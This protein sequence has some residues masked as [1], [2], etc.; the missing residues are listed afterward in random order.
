MISFN[1]I[2]LILLVHWFADFHFQSDRLARS[3]ATSISAL[4]EH[5]VIYT[6]TWIIW[7]FALF[8][9][10]SNSLGEMWIKCGIFG[11]I[12][13]VCHWITDYFTSKK[14]KKLFDMQD[15]HNG[16]VV[17]GFDQILHYVQLF[18]TYIWL[19]DLTV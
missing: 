10:C 18:A 5:I 6:F 3:K 15:F 12:T 4:T 9:A 2:I 17:I 19:R 13:F 14:V 11:G 1:I 7:A 8:E 16:F